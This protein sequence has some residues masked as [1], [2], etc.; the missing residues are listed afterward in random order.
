MASSLEKHQQTRSFHW[1][2]NQRTRRVIRNQSQKS[3]HVTFP[4]SS[5]KEPI[6]EWDEY[7]SLNRKRQ[8]QNVSNQSQNRIQSTITRQN[9]KE[10]AKCPAAESNRTREETTQLAPCV[11]FPNLKNG[12]LLRH[13]QNKH[14]KTH[15]LRGYLIW[16]FERERGRERNSMSVR[17][18]SHRMRS[19]LQ[20]VH[21]NYGTH[22]SEWECSHRL[23]AAS[24]LLTSPV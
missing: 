16:Y 12:I 14:G 11:F 6:T 2:A 24:N 13:R 7:F 4:R 17:L 10:K 5:M 9:S 19:T 22:C 8:T 21:A 15:G 23:Q 20:H 1:P 18:R 3:N